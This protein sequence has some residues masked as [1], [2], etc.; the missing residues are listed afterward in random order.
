MADSAD[1]LAVGSG[2][3]RRERLV[4]LIAFHVGHSHLDQFMCL[5]RPRGLRDDGIADA[6][7]ADPNDRLQSV[8][9]APKLTALL[10]GKVHGAHLT[11]EIFE[12]GPPFALRDLASQE[13]AL[14]EAV[15]AKI[16]A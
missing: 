1:H 2:R 14:Y 9:K 15:L 13:A 10:V 12:L 3:E 6:G 11:A 4:P 7:L 5:E 16:D 8:G